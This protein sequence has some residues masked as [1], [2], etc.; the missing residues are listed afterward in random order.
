VI[1]DL[2]ES[3]ISNYGSPFFDKFFFHGD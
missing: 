2:V 3:F 1:G